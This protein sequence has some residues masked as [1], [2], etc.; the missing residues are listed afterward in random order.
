M[1]LTSP[2]KI[3]P[4]IIGRKPSPIVPNPF[5]WQKDVKYY[6]EYLDYVTSFNASLT[7]NNGAEQHIHDEN[8]QHNGEDDA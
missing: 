6:K 2:R 7:R 1:S 8:C 5:F 4:K 3:R